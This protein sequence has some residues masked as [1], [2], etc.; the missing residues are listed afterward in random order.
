LAAPLA[1]TAPQ[2]DLLHR[3]R[4]ATWRGNRI[5]WSAY[6][7]VLPF[8][9]PFLLFSLLAIIFGIYVSFTQW[10]I[11]GSPK[12]VGLANYLQAL[13]SSDLPRAWLN[14]LRYG[15]MTVP[16]VII[17]ALLL[18]IFVNLRLPGST[19]ARTTFF[20]PYVLSATV[21]AVV[22]VWILDTQHGILNH[23]LTLVGLPQIPWITNPSWALP[24]VSGVGI[25]WDTGFIMVILLAA[26]QD[27]PHELREA[28][29]IDGATPFQVN[30]HVVLPLLRPVLSLAL[31]LEII[32]A[33]RVFSLI[34]LMTDGGPA[35]A[36]ESV[37]H[38]IYEAGFVNY[39]LGLAAAI[40]LLLFLTILIITAIQL[41]LMR[42][43]S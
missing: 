43:A 30:L 5:D 3:L 15:L 33:L 6:L 24:S 42:G 8:F 28:A 2:G 38:L 4:T 20:T 1:R 10:G 21:V 35:G 32:N 37:V 23:Y 17:L 26:L 25:W 13:Q 40:A 34:Y 18:A 14:T 11:I 19:F 41:R 27:I 12:W 39:Q 36:T 7:F 22:W 31:T 29:A 16:S 9:V